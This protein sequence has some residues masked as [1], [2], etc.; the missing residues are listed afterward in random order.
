MSITFRSA[1]LGVVPAW[2]FVTM[3][4]YANSMRIHEFSGGSA[5]DKRANANWSK[6]LING[7]FIGFFDDYVVMRL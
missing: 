7:R 2:F 3:L 4:N 5:I 1:V 6:H